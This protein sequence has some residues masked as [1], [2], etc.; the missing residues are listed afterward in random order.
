MPFP[1][2]VGWLGS[3]ALAHQRLGHPSG[4]KTFPTKIPFS[5]YGVPFTSGGLL[6]PNGAIIFFRAL[7][8]ARQ[9]CSN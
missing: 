1:P 8:D 3:G 4:E 2:G 7:V 6:A 5:P 9:R